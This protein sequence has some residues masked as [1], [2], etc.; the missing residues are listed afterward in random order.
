MDWKKV[1]GTLA[2]TVA[3]A[4]GGPL[5]GGV[6]VAIGDLLGISEP[7]Q[8]KIKVAIENGALTGEQVTG[9]RTLEM[10]LK[11]EESERGFRYADLEFK[12]R[13]SARLRDAD[14]TKAGRRNHRADVM[15]VLAVAVICGLVWAIWIDPNINEFLKGIATLV[16]GRFLG[17]LDNIYS[18]EFGTTRG[19]QSKDATINQLSAGV[20]ALLPV[21]TACIYKKTTATT[22]HA[23][24]SR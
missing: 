5:A 17:Y 16:L 7:T 12:D 3:T 2:P 11:A 9:I 4:L 10:T 13:D 8:D 19:S 1:I 18:F 14:I 24:M 23:W 6:V 22:W 21:Y 20:G 15:F